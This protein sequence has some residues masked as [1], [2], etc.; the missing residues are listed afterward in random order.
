MKVEIHVLAWTL[1]VQKH[2]LCQDFSCS[3]PRD[4]RV[5]QTIA[6]LLEPAGFWRTLPRISNLSG[7]PCVKF[8][9]IPS[10]M[11]PPAWHPEIAVLG[12]CKV[13]FLSSGIY[14]IL[15]NLVQYLNAAWHP[16]TTGRWRIL[17]SSWNWQGSGEPVQHLR[18]IGLS[19]LRTRS[20]P[21]CHES[22]CSAHE[23][24]RD[25]R[26]HTQFS[27]LTRFWPTFLASE[28]C[29]LSL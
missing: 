2:P 29:F 11:S 17:F 26:T 25:W 13:M 14:I 6:Q 23:D 4:K 1:Q 21:L 3:A 28:A 19:L 22:S 16:D 27:E 18:H 9:N 20:H 10:A 5:L 7:S 24:Y 8:E 12:N 15:E